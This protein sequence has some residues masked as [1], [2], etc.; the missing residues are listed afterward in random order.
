ME[1]NNSAWSQYKDGWVDDMYKPYQPQETII[2]DIKVN[3]YPHKKLPN[4]VEPL[5]LRRS[6]GLEFEKMFPYYPCPEGWVQ[7]SKRPS[8]CIRKDTNP[9]TFYTNKAFIVKKQFIPEKKDDK[10]LTSLSN[11]SMNPYTGQ[12]RE[13]LYGK[14]SPHAQRYISL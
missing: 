5:L 14:K 9:A 13:Y 12:R 4:G 10:D 1:F 11:L 6:K 7:D 3:I 8:F 2:N